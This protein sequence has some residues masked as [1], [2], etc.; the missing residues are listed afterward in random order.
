MSWKPRLTFTSLALLVLAPASIAQGELVLDTVHGHSLE[1]SVT[2]E[3]PDRAVGVYLPP[4][5]SESPERRY[6]VLYLLHGIGGDASGL[7]RVSTAR[8]SG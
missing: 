7:D 8:K 2:G 3:S 6:P 5:Y 4:S 1:N